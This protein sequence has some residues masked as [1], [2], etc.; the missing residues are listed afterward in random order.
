MIRSPRHRAG[1]SV[2]ARAPQ[3]PG[4]G[5]G[6]RRRLIGTPSRTA[7]TS[8]YESG[9][10]KVPASR[11][12]SVPHQGHAPSRRAISPQD[13][14]SRRAA[15]HPRRRSRSRRQPEA[16]GSSPQGGARVEGRPLSRIRVRDQVPRGLPAVGQA[17]RQ[18]AHAA[19][20][21]P[22]PLPVARQRPR[23]Q[24]G[25]RDGRQAHPRGHPDPPRRGPQ[26]RILQ[27]GNA[28]HAENVLQME[29]APPPG[30]RPP[31]WPRRGRWLPGRPH[32]GRPGRS[33]RARIG[34]TA[35]ERPA[36]PWRSH[37]VRRTPLA[38]AP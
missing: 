15:P 11:G 7:R 21:L 16:A 38:P 35:A 17:G 30:A 34:N 22:D 27:T 19:A 6:P 37:S 3:D 2:R 12:G 28:R 13:G 29:L 36:S 23:A 18:G 5:G 26:G 20:A 4:D 24:A 8:A 1:P 14:H 31:R 25:G 33:P 32:P 9:S 10:G